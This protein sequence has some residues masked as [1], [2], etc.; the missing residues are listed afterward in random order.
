MN[1]TSILKSLASFK[2]SFGPQAEVVLDGIELI[3]PFV[4]PPAALIPALIKLG[5]GQVDER[6]SIPKTLPQSFVDQ[7]NRLDPDDLSQIPEILK[8][9]EKSL[10][11]TLLGE[12]WASTVR[13]KVEEQ[14]KTQTQQERAER[15]QSRVNILHGEM[16]RNPEFRDLYDRLLFCFSK[17]PNTKTL[18][19]NQINEYRQYVQESVK[20]GEMSSEDGNVLKETMESCF[21]FLFKKLHFTGDKELK[22]G[23]REV[24]GAYQELLTCRWKALQLL[25]EKNL[26]E[27]DGLIASLER[28]RGAGYSQF[29]D[30]LSSVR[31]CWSPPT[32][33]GLFELR[34]GLESI[35]KKGVNSL[36][37]PSVLPHSYTPPSPPP[38]SLDLIK[39]RGKNVVD[40]SI[41][42]GRKWG[43]VGVILLGVGVLGYWGQGEVSEWWMLLILGFFLITPSFF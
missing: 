38:S 17:S 22:E 14:S 24:Q 10:H 35:H 20:K 42:V 33:K 13:G 29:P 12:K 4:C 30:L 37:V 19:K 28:L 39:K 8:L 15:E 43:K 3:L 41:Q 6:R 36:V 21:P 11:Q 31:S 25:K 1:A 16:A 32:P 9:M 23:V 40:E 18:I 2:R 27:L 34:Q 26:R 5:L 7:C